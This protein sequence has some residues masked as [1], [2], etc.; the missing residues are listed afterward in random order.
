MS[1]GFYIQKLVYENEI[2]II[3]FKISYILLNSNFILHI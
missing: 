1:T 2:L 3:K